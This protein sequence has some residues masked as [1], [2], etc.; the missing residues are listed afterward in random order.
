MIKSEKS[1]L[2]VVTKPE[3]EGVA[4]GIRFCEKKHT[5]INWKAVLSYAK[6]CRKSVSIAIARLNRPRLSPKSLSSFA[7]Q[8]RPFG[9][10]DFFPVHVEAFAIS[11]RTGPFKSAIAVSSFLHIFHSILFLPI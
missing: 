4:A 3:D 11:A 1:L 10:P 9:S 2:S 5:C 6:S 8:N 7:P